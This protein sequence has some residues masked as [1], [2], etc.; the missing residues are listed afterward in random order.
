VRL[1][2][3]EANDWTDRLPAV[4]AA[5]TRFKATS[6]TFDGEAVVAG[7]DGV[8]RFDDLRR[9]ESA[10][11]AFLY[12]FDLLE[13]TGRAPRPRRRLDGATRRNL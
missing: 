1:Y 5:A 8:T 11:A 4:A 9:R 7:S 3:R 6:F 13:Q 10:R 12:A 2:T